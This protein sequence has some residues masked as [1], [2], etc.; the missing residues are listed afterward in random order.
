MAKILIISN[1]TQ[2]YYFCG[3]DSEHHGESLSAC[4]HPCIGYKN[5]T[6]E[7]QE[8]FPKWCPLEDK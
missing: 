5:I 1:Y 8:S 6:Y 4:E 2:C 3:T 7:D